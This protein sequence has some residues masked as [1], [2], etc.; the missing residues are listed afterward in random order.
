MIKKLY[1]AP[2][3]CSLAAHIALHEAGLT[4]NYVPVDLRTRQ[5]SD[6]RNLADLNSKGYV[7]VLELED[8]QIL[9]EV[10]V[11][12]QYIADL[13][14]EKGLA[15]PAGV[16]PRYRLQEWL[17]FIN[18][19]LHKAFGPL[20]MPGASEEVKAQSRA[21][22]LQ[23][24]TWVD[25]QLAGR[26]YLVGEQFTVADVYLFVVAGWTKFTGIDVQELTRLGSYLGR[27]AQRPAVEAAMRAE[28]LV[29]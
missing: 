14:P 29:K 4:F 28:G 27:I 11:V 24:L 10:P 8:G 6:G 19:E 23:R 16:L 15:P 18:S 2:G 7:P 25:A 9:T 20:F 17:S 22:V 21:R 26:T 3:A 12:L 13:A 1:G 5:A